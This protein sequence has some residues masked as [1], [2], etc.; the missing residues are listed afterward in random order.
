MKNADQGALGAFFTCL[1]LWER[2]DADLVGFL[3]KLDGWLANDIG[4]GLKAI[5][6][7]WGTL[8]GHVTPGTEQEMSDEIQRWMVDTWPRNL[9]AEQYELIRHYA[10][11]G[12]QKRS[13]DSLKWP[14]TT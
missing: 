3:L 12:Y 6:T 2:E 7:G 4:P 11:S 10:E 8:G 1:R 14:W 13:A 5:G 9:T